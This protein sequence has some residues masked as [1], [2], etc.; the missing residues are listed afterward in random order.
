V[1]YFTCNHVTALDIKSKVHLG[2]K[3]CKLCCPC[4]TPRIS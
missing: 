1:F 2:R 4:W 3:G